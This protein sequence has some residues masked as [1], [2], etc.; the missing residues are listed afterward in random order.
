MSSAEYRRIDEEANGVEQQLQQRS[1]IFGIIRLLWFVAIIYIGALLLESESI[2]SIYVGLAML[3]VFLFLTMLHARLDQSLQY[4]RNRRAACNRGL[5]RIGGEWQ[6]DQDDG[7]NAITSW[8][9]YAHDLDLIGPHGLFALLNTT[10]SQAGTRYLADLLFD[11]QAQT[12]DQWKAS[13]QRLSEK[14]ERRINWQAAMQLETRLWSRDEEQQCLEAYQQWL[15]AA[16]RP[17]IPLPLIMLARIILGLLLVGGFIAVGWT[18]LWTGCILLATVASVLNDRA[19][20]SWD[21]CD[22]DRIDRLLRSWH[23]GLELVLLDEQ[24]E[25]CFSADEGGDLKKM[26][27]SL[28]AQLQAWH[29]LALRSNPFWRFGLGALL[30]SDWHY[31]QRL[32]KWRLTEAVLFRAQIQVLARIDVLH[33][34]ANYAAEQGGSYAEHSDDEQCLFTACNLAHPLMKPDLRV[35]NNVALCA[36]EVLM[37]TGANASGKS[38]F[39]RSIALAVLM[40]RLGIPVCA[41]DCQLQPQRLAT[42]M[43]IHDALWEGLSRFQAEVKQLKQV[44]ERA[45]SPGEPVMLILDEILGGTNSEERRQGTLAF[46]K[47]FRDYQGLLL[48]TTHDLSLTEIVEHEPDRIRCFHFADRAVLDEADADVRFDYKLRPGILQS[49]NALQVMRAAGL[50]IE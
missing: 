40:S 16:N 39:L 28:A 47:H 21:Q 1:I 26:S 34:L 42:V 23:R 4:Q 10:A 50:P 33:A 14:P 22:V 13:I 18:W 17:G 45:A 46:I 31:R 49:T 27:Q 30:L 12:D 41:D 7:T 48:I 8:H 9:P 44:M 43:R 38:T 36:G 32:Q 6:H 37:L 29:G 20:A 15:S 19:L 35:G 5:E 25:S 11:E 3:V 2:W 24:K